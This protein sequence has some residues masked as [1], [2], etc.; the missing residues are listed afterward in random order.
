MRS[1]PSSADHLAIEVAVGDDVAGQLGEL[2]RLAQA[3]RERDRRGQR[4]LHGLGQLQQQ[5]RG[6]QAGR[7]GA[8][9]DAC[10]AR[11]RAI[12]SVMPTRPPLEAL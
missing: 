10:C 11:S 7:H 1:A 4:L 8:H 3:R 12:G 2:R 9:A 6:E 5:R